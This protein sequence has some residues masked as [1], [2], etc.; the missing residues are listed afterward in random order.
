MWSARAIFLLAS[1]AKA[2]GGVGS[3][4]RDRSA[5]FRA[6]SHLPDEEKPLVPVRR[7]GA[8]DPRIDLLR[9]FALLTIC[10]DHVPGNPLAVIT[11]RNFG[12]ADAAELFVILAGL[13][14]MG[15]YGGTIERDGL[16]HGLR[17]VA[18]RCLQVYGAQIALLALT[19]AIV[20]QWRLAF[21]LPPIRLAPFFEQPISGLAHGLMLSAQPAS[22]NILPLYV[23]LLA[24]FP[25]LYVGLRLIPGLIIPMS[26]SL[27]LVANLDRRFN[28]TNWLDGQ[29]WYFNPF[30]WQFLFLLGMIGAAILRA[31]G[32]ELPRI[33]ALRLAA[34]AFLGVAMLWAAPW[35]NFGVADFHPIALPAPDKTTLA[36]LRVLNILALIYL[37][38]SSPGLRKLAERPGMSP[39]VACGRHSLEV[40]SF[41]TLLG[42]FGR[43]L[44][45]TFGP[46]G[47]LA[48]SINVVAIACM[49]LLA[50]FLAQR[51]RTAM[52]RARS[53][54]EMQPGGAR[55]L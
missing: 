47:M 19:L 48:V 11:L 32:G 55:A 14:A 5:Q 52:A 41:A 2:G 4:H 35:A 9:G 22:L 17:R 21:G 15:A 30:A 43:L 23:V 36:P 12:F 1:R 8:R 3:L 13:S 40:F 54:G 53:F 18:V 39:L 16:R 26:V 45:R 37:A 51:R 29:G 49:L 25:L 34:W 46:S 27:W 38:L 50:L 33:R 7:S 42:L 20:W 10:V 24:A 28:L 6:A 31:H 44:L